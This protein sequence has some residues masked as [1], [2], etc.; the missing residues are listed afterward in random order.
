MHSTAA[1]ASLLRL[2]LSPPALSAPSAS[3]VA[4]REALAALP[5]LARPCV[6]RLALL[7]VPKF[8]TVVMLPQRAWKS[9]CWDAKKDTNCYAEVRRHDN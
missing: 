8:G 4:C 5:L 2:P 7:T 3:P 9:S 1:A 6:A